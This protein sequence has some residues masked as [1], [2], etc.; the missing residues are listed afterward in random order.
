M[1]KNIFVFLFSFFFFF[2]SSIVFGVPAGPLSAKRIAQVS[3]AC[4]KVFYSLAESSDEVQEEEF[5]KQLHSLVEASLP[6]AK[7]ALLTENDAIDLAKKRLAFLAAKH[8]PFPSAEELENAAV[9]AYPLY[10]RGDK[11]RIIHK[12]NPFATTVTEGVLYEARN[13]V[14]KVGARSVRIR[15]M[16]GIDGN[17]EEALK[18]DEKASLVKREEFKANV[19]EETEL[20]QKTWIDDNKEAIWEQVL[21]E[22]SAQNEK[23]GYTNL[24]EEWLTSAQLLERLCS[25]KFSALSGQARMKKAY[26]QHLLEAS[27]EA[28]Q[29]ALAQSSKILPLG[30]WLSPAA[31]MQRRAKLEAERLAAIE[32][33]K[34]AQRKLEEERLARIAEEKAAEERAIAEAKAR[35]L[36]ELKAQ[37]E[38]ARLALRRKKMI[39]IIIA[40]AAVLLIAAVIGFLIWRK[41][42]SEGPDYQKFFEGRGRLQKEFWARVEAD[43]DNFR[44]VAYL[45]PNMNEANTA[46]SKLSYITTDKDG[47]LSCARDIFFGAY[48]H[49]E[50]AVCFVG[51]VRLNYALWREATA[52]LPEL[53]GAVYFKVSPEPSVMLDLPDMADGKD[54]DLQIKS[55]GT[56]DITSESGEFSRCFKYSS[57]SKTNAM[58]FLEK[59]DIQ[60]DG[61]IIQVATPEGNVGKD[62]N[63]IFEF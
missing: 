4:E 32:A 58:A 11:V 8:Y 23:N 17:E 24:E 37:E 59:T 34:E 9:T 2:I 15:D 60:E 22:L 40:I 29:I 43:P 47:N 26:E 20:S 13:G 55:L 49:Q 52:I 45:F 44:Y 14:I 3:V 12:K 28:P 53:P 61:I 56:E 31:E 7:V 57:N 25:I 27:I 39:P 1:K 30:E 51:G 54:D 41:K 6:V 10:Q 35:E 18:F 50:G 38:A 19:L 16:L 62:I 5:C 21:L 33:A 48:P 42:T 46:L 36:A 63:G